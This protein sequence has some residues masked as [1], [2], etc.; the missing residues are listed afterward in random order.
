VSEGWK[1]LLESEPGSIPLAREAFG[2]RGI[3]DAPAT[4]PNP[5]LGKGDIGA[6]D[7]GQGQDLLRP[8]IRHHTKHSRF[9]RF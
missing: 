6:Y 9:L 7:Q 5:V 3:P 4:A 2:N 1:T 8:I